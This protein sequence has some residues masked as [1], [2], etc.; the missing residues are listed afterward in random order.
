MPRGSKGDLARRAREVL[1]HDLFV[2]AFEDTTAEL[3]RT[4]KDAAVGSAESEDAIYELKAL[5][6]VHF[7]LQTHIRRA[8]GVEE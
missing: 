4:I 2:A 1:E 8:V 6:R 5:G 7:K 3:F